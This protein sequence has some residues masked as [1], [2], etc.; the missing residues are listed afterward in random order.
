MR[1]P[2]PA[3]ALVERVRR[4]E[5]GGAPG[6][7]SHGKAEQAEH[8]RQSETHQF[9]PLPPLPWS[10]ARRRACSRID[11]HCP[12]W[13]LPGQHASVQGVP[14]RLMR[15]LHQAYVA[16]NV[17]VTVVNMA[18]WMPL[19]VCTE[20]VTGVPPRVIPV[21]V[22]AGTLQRQHRL[23]AVCARADRRDKGECAAAP[24]RPRIVEP[25]RPSTHCNSCRWEISGTLRACA[26]A[27]MVSAPACG[28]GA[29]VCTFAANAP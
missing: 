25:F 22:P 9:S 24:V 19:I 26:A 1:R 6:R 10:S 16:T 17:A 29:S 15:S 5:T 27:T 13:R 8:N 28:A 12:S 20:Y 14:S 2:Q 18:Y 11:A 7:S 21:S 23:Q 3:R 4:D